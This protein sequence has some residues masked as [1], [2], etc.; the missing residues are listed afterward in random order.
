MFAAGV[1]PGILGTV[2]LC[3][4]VQWTVWVDPASGP[5]GPRSIWRERFVALKGVWAVT[6]L[7]VVVMGGIYGGVF[8][9]TEGAGFG[10]FGA[11]CFALARGALTWRT[12]LDSLV[13]SAAPRRCC[14][15]S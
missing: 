11:L 15:P 8:T 4:A 6:L 7:F 2:L 3:L 1:L 9:A 5:R 10:A 12:L 14:S 13:E